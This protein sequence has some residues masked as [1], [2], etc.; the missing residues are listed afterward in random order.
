MAKHDN[1][2]VP[3]LANLLE[4]LRLANFHLSNL[5]SLAAAK[6]Q[7][8]SET[9][10]AAARHYV[11]EEFSIYQRLAELSTDRAMKG[12]LAMAGANHG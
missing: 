2:E 5:V 10:L 9:I 1:T 3:D 8:E 11:N 4:E 7:D 12:G 6:A